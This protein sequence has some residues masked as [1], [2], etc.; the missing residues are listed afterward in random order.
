[1]ITQSPARI[2]K[3]DI[4]KIISTENF[5]RTEFLAKGSF[6]CLR[7]FNEEILAPSCSK[8]ITL[9]DNSV[10]IIIPI[11]GNIELSGYDFIKNISI[12][13]SVFIARKKEQI[14]SVKNIS[15]EHNICYL[16]ISWQLDDIDEDQ[17]IT[18][19]FDLAPKNQMHT[20]S[21][22]LGI[23]NYIGLIDGREEGYY[24]LSNKNNGLFVYVINGAFEFQNR[25]LESGEALCLWD[26]CEIEYEALSN[27]ALL[28]FFEVL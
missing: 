20:L 2:I 17:L 18:E 19:K 9:D 8:E 15:Q 6:K 27:N 5:Q 7:N 28:L 11:F 10:N 1:M 13:E 4:Q 25:L 26:V 21:A 22:S 16:L 24:Q 14:I 23:P 12:E 3:S